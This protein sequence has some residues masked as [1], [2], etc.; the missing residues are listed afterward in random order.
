MKPI[1]IIK[2]ERDEALAKL[3]AAE[4][5][6][7]KKDGALRMAKALISD[8]LAQ[9]AIAHNAGGDVVTTTQW[10]LSEDTRKA[11][12]EALSFACGQVLDA[13]H[14]PLEFD[15]TTLTGPAHTP[16]VNLPPLGDGPRR[17]M[18]IERV[19]LERSRCSCYVVNQTGQEIQCPRCKALE[20]TSQPKQALAELL[21][22]P[23]EYLEELE[24]EWRWKKDEPRCGYKEAYDKLC[25][26]I[27]RLRAA[28]EVKK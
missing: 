12:D 16:S 7:A 6:C 19:T 26:C 2:R 28:L 15:S 1:D 14:T 18:L 10:L 27:A 20:V 21:A 4:A 25:V 17:K 8:G 11:I 3:A 24:C 13:A 23:L 9:A 22:E 5:A